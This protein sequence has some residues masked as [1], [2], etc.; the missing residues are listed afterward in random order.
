MEPFDF[1]KYDTEGAQWTEGA[2][3]GESVAMYVGVTAKGD[4]TFELV[5]EDGTVELLRPGV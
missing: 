1:Y 3:E 4:G 2:R 5:R